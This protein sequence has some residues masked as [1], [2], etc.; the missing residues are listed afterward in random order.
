MRGAGSGLYEQAAIDN[1]FDDW[2]EPKASRGDDANDLQNDLENVGHGDVLDDVVD[3]GFDDP[4]RGFSY[5]RIASY[6]AVGV[7]VISVADCVDKFSPVVLDRF[8]YGHIY[9]GLKVIRT[10]DTAGYYAVHLGWNWPAG[11]IISRSKSGSPAG[12]SPCGD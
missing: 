6:R 5:P 12:V 1:G 11:E 4:G 10:G 7:D 8:A 3:V 2:D 9:R